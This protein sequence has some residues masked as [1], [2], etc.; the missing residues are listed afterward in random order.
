MSVSV[1]VRDVIRDKRAKNLFYNTLSLIKNI[2]KLEYE[3]V[4]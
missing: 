1:I 2:T 3:Y 4:F